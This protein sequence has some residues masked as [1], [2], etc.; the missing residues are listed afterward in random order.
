MLSRHRAL[1]RPLIAMVTS[2]IRVGCRQITG[3]SCINH[4]K[5]HGPALEVPSLSYVYGQ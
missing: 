5:L 4:L 1:E 3:L 2:S